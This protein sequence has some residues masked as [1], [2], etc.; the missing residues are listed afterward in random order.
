[1]W[2]VLR[3]GILL[4][5][6]VLVAGNTLLDRAR[7]TDWDKPLRVG[8]FP[9]VADDSEIARRHVA[10]LDAGDFAAIETFLAREARLAG[11]ALDRPAQVTLYPPV[12]QRPPLRDPRAGAL[13]TGLWSLRLRGYAWRAAGSTPAQIRLF[14]LYHDPAR[15]PVVPHS[16]GLQ[17]GL[18]GVVH[19]F[20][21][22]DMTGANQVVIAHELLH[23]LGATDKY[24]PA[25]G[26]PRWPDGYAQPQASPRHPQRRAEI[27]AG[28]RALSASEAETPDSL[29]DAVVGGATAREIR[30]RAD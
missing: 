22:G 3:I 30:W 4:A 21:A 6:L 14:V 15:S 5:V 17:K 8:V 7:T 9:I 18:V 2:R 27:M 23:T 25:S 29:D 12:P 1:M 26:L 11:V 28:R 10:A 20:A 16:L 19:A 13:A 24:D